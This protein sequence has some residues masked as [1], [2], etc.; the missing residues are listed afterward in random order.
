MLARARIIATAALFLPAARPA[1]GE[2]QPVPLAPA[3]ESGQSVTPAFEGWYRHSDGTYRLSFGYYNR[4]SKE[5]LEVPVGPDNFVAPGDS[6]QGQPTRFE[7]RRHWGVFAVAVPATFGD[8]QVTWTLVVRGQRFV[9]PGR[10]KPGWEI[11]ALQGEAGSG[12]TPPVLRFDPGGPEGRG[13]AGVTAGRLTVKAGQPLDLTVWA[14]DDGKA[15][16]SIVSAGREGVPVTLTLFKH[17]GPGG[18][19]FGNST[20]A[21]DPAT[22]KATTTVTFSAAGDYLLRVR[23]NDASGVT[24]AGHAQCCWTNGFVPVTVTP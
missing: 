9:I 24:G 19:T 5:V 18:V 15:A 6:D 1:P 16:S 3:R 11:D 21:V 14:S 2:A 10:L 20:P 17:Q 13:P 23:A 4:N 7:P 8:G 12:N 22:A